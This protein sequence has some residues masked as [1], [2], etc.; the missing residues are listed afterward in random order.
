MFIRH[1]TYICY[2][3][4]KF[5]IRPRTF[6][7]RYFSSCTQIRVVVGPHTKNFSLSVTSSHSIYLI[8]TDHRFLRARSQ[9]IAIQTCP[10]RKQ[11][12]LCEYIL[13]IVQAAFWLSTS[14][15]LFI[16]LRFSRP[17][18]TLFVHIETIFY[19]R[20]P[21]GFVHRYIDVY[22]RPFYSSHI[23]TVHPA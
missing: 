1:W 9:T 7:R 18:R 8:I 12:V 17:R 14:S 13:Y 2:E 5:K 16:Y 23:Y 22:I 3:T 6:R 21:I 10:F 11:Y 4:D 19:F 15:V 20:E